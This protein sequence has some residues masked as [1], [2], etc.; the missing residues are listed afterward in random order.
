MGL[1]VQKYG[2]TSVG[3]AGRIKRVAKRVVAAA[4][5]GQ[6]VCVV[7]SAM[8][9]STDELLDLAAQVTPIPHAR[10]LDMLLT[11]G[12]R[13]SMALLSMAIIDLGREAVSFTGSQA[14]IVTDTSH[15]RA[16]IVDVRAR[17]VLEALEEGKIVIVAGFQGVSTEF[18]V[19][20]LG[21]GGSD[22]TAVALAAALDADAC[23][24][25]TDV[26]G[27]FTADPRIVPEARKLHAV[28]Y[29]EM[30]ELAAAGA[31][32]LMLR[33]VEYARNHG[34]LL[35]VRS[36]FT[37]EDGTWIREEDVR[38]EQAIISGI[39]H[40][41]SESKVT[42]LGV[43][44]RPGVAARVFRPLADESV[45]IDMIVQNV[46]EDGR[47]DISF[48]L[49]NDDLPRAEPI[50]K[51]TAEEV[52]AEGIEMDRDIAKVSLVGAGMKTHPGVAADMFDA[53]SEAGINLEI[54]STSSIRISCVVRAKEVERAVRAVHDKF[55]LS[56]EVIL[57][58]E[59]PATVTD[60]LRAVKAEGES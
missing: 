25:F 6:K 28:S 13:I 60:E 49:P 3:D 21:R 45:N 7:V 1:M 26:D 58:E 12:E 47:T 29:E 54:I 57:R 56:E 19:T 52:G 15:G 34:V 43:P 11:A 32:V 30:L 2:G 37:G 53:L 33:S 59:H 39:A 35:H 22:T 4:A 55:R 42:I 23:E 14:G 20:T 36:S 31:R 50:L 24:I 18:D 5:S 40:D 8:N 41:V 16:Q 10:E 51:A 38:M 27:V 9:Q 44:D 46:A 48:T 17:R